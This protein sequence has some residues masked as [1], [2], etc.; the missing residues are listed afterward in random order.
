MP[1]FIN[2]GGIILKS[3]E[4]LKRMQCLCKTL[5]DEL[6]TLCPGKLW[7]KPS[8]IENYPQLYPELECLFMNLLYIITVSIIATKS[9]YI[10]L[11]IYVG[12]RA[13]RNE[14]HPPPSNV[15]VNSSC[16]CKQTHPPPQ[17]RLLILSYI[18]DS[19]GDM[20]VKNRLLDS[21]GEGER[22]VI[23]E[24]SMETCTFPLVEQMTSASSIHEAGYPK[25]WDSPEG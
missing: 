19:K 24:N 25:L 17:S 2:K 15:K 4:V 1:H 5:T 13:R 3:W 20:C 21:A 6:L 18:Q 16:L 10:V 7:L 9:F 8:Q 22:G 11:N 23:W 12:T 14:Y